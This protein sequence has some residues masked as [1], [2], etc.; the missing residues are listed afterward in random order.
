MSNWFTS[1]L[2]D[3]T[4][5][6]SHYMD[7]IQSCGNHMEQLVR[8][9]FFKVL[10]FVLRDIKASRDKQTIIRL[11][12]AV[13]WKFLG[14]DHGQ[15]LDNDIFR[16]LREGDGTHKHPIRFCWGKRTGLKKWDLDEE[17]DNLQYVLLETFENLFLNIVSRV[18]DS[19][20]GTQIQLK[21]TGT[22]IPTLERSKSV[23]NTSVSERLC[24]D[25][26]HIVFKELNRY[27]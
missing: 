14:R 20:L 21:K 27:V 19:E 18:V 16:V 11:L 22:A 2:R 6:L 3:K 5:K 1:A 17:P 9:N 26:F 7:N 10:S 24:G 4:N 23:I 12:D 25:A 15:I 13:Q 8:N